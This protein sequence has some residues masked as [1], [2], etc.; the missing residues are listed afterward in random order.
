[1]THSVFQVRS[2][3]EDVDVH[4][5]AACFLVNIGHPPVLGLRGILAY[6]HEVRQCSSLHDE[7]CHRASALVPAPSY[8]SA[9]TRIEHQVK[10]AIV[11]QNGTPVD[12]AKTW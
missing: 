2:C 5:R 1:M 12:N 7:A 9:N 6:S 10:R 4:T 3:V 11:R 8:D